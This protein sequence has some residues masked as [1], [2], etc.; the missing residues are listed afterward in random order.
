MLRSDL[1]CFWMKIVIVKF[2]SSVSVSYFVC[3]RC[4]TTEHSSDDNSTNPLD[5]GA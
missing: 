1:L 3:F 4:N 5:G 2:Q